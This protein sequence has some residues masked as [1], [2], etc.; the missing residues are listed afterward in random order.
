LVLSE[1][2]LE[3][4]ESPLPLLPLLPDPHLICPQVLPG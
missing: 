3:L 2:E 4:L 1:L